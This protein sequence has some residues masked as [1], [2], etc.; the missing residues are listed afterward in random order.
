M[1]KNIMSVDLEDYF[2]DLPFSN[3]EFPK[4]DLKYSTKNFE[5]INKTLA[6]NGI[7]K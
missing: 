7:Q 1:Q 2:C 3:D 4:L 6:N 5:K